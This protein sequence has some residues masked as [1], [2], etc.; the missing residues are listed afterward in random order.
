[1]QKIEIKKILKKL[2][3][4]ISL[5]SY[6]LV[7]NSDKHKRL[8]TQEI[9]IAIISYKGNISVPPNNAFDLFYDYGKED[10]NENFIEFNLWFDGKESDLTLSVTFFSSGEYSIE[11][12]HVL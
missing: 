8:S 3:K 12:I 5:C 4:N 7:F 6:S 1:M 2:V 10:S 11:D 9:E